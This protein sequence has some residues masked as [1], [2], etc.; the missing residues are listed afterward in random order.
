VRIGVP[1]V[2][3]RGLDLTSLEIQIQDM[4]SK[5]L[6]QIA[7][8]N[9]ADL[10]ALSE[11]PDLPARIT[12][13]LPGYTGTISRAMADVPNGASFVSLMEELAS[14]PAS[15]VPE[16]FRVMLRAEA[17]RVGRLE[18][19]RVRLGELL[20]QWADTPP[21]SWRPAEAKVAAPKVLRAPA[22]EPA[23][24]RPSRAVIAA[25]AAAT[26]GRQR[27]SGAPPKAAPAVD[28][29]RVQ[30]IL[31]TT[32]ERLANS[33]DAGLAEQVL[34]A[35]ITHRAKGRYDDLKPQEV[36]DALREL[37][38]RGRARVSAGRWRL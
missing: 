38:K 19:E 9:V 21:A 31:D 28:L 5:P 26:A 14:I 29:A 33:P 15:Q 10:F 27:A 7:L 2:N 36:R 22:A 18:G 35:G 11:M 23:P 32:L 3:L 20:D 6:G 37:G 24:E 17:E 1:V 13:R 30:W 16:S 34:I 25:D 4:V 12:K 8:N